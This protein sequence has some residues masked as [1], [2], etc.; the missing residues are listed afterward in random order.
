VICRLSFRQAPAS[1][2]SQASARA[3]AHTHACRR[4]KGKQRS[5]GKDHFS[6]SCEDYLY[7]MMTI[8]KTPLQRV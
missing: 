6:F 1:Q 8:L 2:C 3:S 7:G 5:R 4:R